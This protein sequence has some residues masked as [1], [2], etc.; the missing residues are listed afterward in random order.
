[1]ALG[2][3]NAFKAGISFGKDDM[4]VPSSKWKII[5]RTRALRA[6]I[7]AA[8]QRWPHHARR[9][10]DPRQGRGRLASEATNLIADEMMHQISS[11]ERVERGRSAEVNSTT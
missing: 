6:G 11:V 9:K 10:C 8:V 5:D 7:R 3:H 1:M 2:F 4:V